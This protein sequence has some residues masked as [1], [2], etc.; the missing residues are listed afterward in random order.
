MYTKKQIKT[1]LDEIMKDNDKVT[2]TFVNTDGETVG[3]IKMPLNSTSE[4]FERGIK[5]FW[6]DN[7]DKYKK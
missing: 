4:E 7:K 3:A 5:K 6:E 1:I 2:I